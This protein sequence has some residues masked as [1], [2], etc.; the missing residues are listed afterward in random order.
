MQ[1][2]DEKDALRIFNIY[3]RKAFKE[4]WNKH[5]NLSFS[6]NE[7]YIEDVKFCV[8]FLSP[9]N[10]NYLMNVLKSNLETN[11]SLFIFSLREMEVGHFLPIIEITK[12]DIII[13]D[14][15][16]RL[17]AA[18]SLGFKSVPALVLSSDNQP[19]PCSKTYQIEEVALREVPVRSHEIIFDDMNEELFRPMRKILYDIKTH[20]LSGEP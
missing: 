12:N 2:D 7:V 20:I 15:S 5:I 11:N 4:H 17:F 13:L 8:S 9:D 16:H 6:I 3:A 18:Y 10:V 1:N 14:G 19:P